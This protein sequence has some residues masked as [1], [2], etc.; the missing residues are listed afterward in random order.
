MNT[1]L[2][3]LIGNINSD[4]SLKELL[5]IYEKENIPLV[6][7]Q[8]HKIKL[9]SLELPYKYENKITLIPLAEYL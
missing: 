1:L 2:V 8:H 6:I 5:D 9:S 4:T 3:T 7:P